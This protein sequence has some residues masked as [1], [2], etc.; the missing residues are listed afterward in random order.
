MA[1]VSC[2][3]W[4]SKLIA[5]TDGEKMPLQKRKRIKSVSC[6]DNE[7]KRA[8]RNDQARKRKRLVSDGFQALNDCIPYNNG[9]KLDRANC[10]FTA[11]EYINQLKK[12]IDEMQTKKEVRNQPFNN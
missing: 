1:R 3:I 4:N 12:T 9:R 5:A 6:V 2:Y 10:L 7:A 11:A 8:R